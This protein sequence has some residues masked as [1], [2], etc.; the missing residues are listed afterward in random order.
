V[1]KLLYVIRSRIKNKNY[2]FSISD[3]K[4]LIITI[5]ANSTML[6]ETSP[7]GD[8]NL[9]ACTTPID[10][11]VDGQIPEWVHGVLYR[12]GKQSL[13]LFPSRDDDRANLPLEVSESWILCVKRKKNHFVCF[14]CSM[15][16]LLCTQ[17]A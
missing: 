17:K 9:P 6:T 16:P 2:A 10:V 8:K 14:S 5:M 11:K 12:V 1:A 15:S 7:F 13:Y 3:K 4:E